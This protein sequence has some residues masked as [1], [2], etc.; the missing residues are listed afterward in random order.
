MGE[1]EYTSTINTVCGGE[2]KGEKIDYR[3]I[4]LQE[5]GYG[6]DAIIIEMSPETVESYIVV[7]ETPTFGISLYQGSNL[8][9]SVE[10]LIKIF[11]K[12]GKKSL[13]YINRYVYLHFLIKMN[14]PEYE[15]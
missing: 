2:Y 12:D 10:Y 14:D 8:K 7:D 11:W 4:I 9:C 15:P 5:K 6:L 13:I 3:G 1:I